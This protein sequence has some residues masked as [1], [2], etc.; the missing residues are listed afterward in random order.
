MAEP[1]DRRHGQLQ[2]DDTTHFISLS[3]GS[4]R[5][6]QDSKELPTFIAASDGWIRIDQIGQAT[7]LGPDGGRTGSFSMPNP[8]SSRYPPIL[9]TGSGAPTVAEL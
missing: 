2:I 9:I 4:S 7:T 3:D 1:A 6:S 8:L 5:N